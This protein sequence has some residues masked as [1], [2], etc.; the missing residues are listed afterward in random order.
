VERLRIGAEFLTIAAQRPAAAQSGADPDTDA[1]KATLEA[2][3]F[4]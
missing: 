2:R 1:W 4:F 3:L